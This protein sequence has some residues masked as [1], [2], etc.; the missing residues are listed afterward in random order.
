MGQ[1]RAAE[2]LL[3]EARGHGD[4]VGAVHEL[5]GQPRPR[6]PVG[7]A[8]VERAPHTAPRAGVIEEA[9]LPVVDVQHQ[10]PP[11]MA[12]REQCE[13]EAR[14]PWLGRDEDVAVDEVEDVP[15]APGEPWIAPGAHPTILD[16]AVAHRR[17]DAV[18]ELG[19][20]DVDFVARRQQAS[21]QIGA[22][23]RVVGQVERE[24]RDLHA[25]PRA[26]RRT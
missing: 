9:E 24:D 15:H 26:S 8:E 7:I 21:E 4:G 16:G 12:S 25:A 14:R 22:A 1:E 11:A 6:E 3:E 5:L 2:A 13:P 19:P 18:A 10:W 17:P 23:R 20:D